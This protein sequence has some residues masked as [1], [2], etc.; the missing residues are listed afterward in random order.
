MAKRK[1][2]HCSFCGRPEEEAEFL[3]DGLEGRICNHCITA[4]NEIVANITRNSRKPVSRNND[5][6]WKEV[7]KPKEIKEILDQYVIGQEEAK[8]ILS[9]AVYNHY[10]R[11]D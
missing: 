7:P 1:T 5:K 11:I 10:K 2:N 9:V 6:S 3:L 8:K 4:A